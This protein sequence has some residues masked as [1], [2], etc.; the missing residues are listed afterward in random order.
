MEKKYEIAELRFSI[1][2]AGEYY[3]ALTDYF[4]EKEVNE[5]RKEDLVFFVHE[6]EN[7]SLSFTPELYSLS[8]TIAFNHDTFF[9]KRPNFTYSV[10]NLFKKDE[11]TEVH[12]FPRNREKNS[13]VKQ[14]LSS[15]RAMLFGAYVG[16]RD[17]NKDFVNAIANYGCLWYIF[18]VVL[19]KKDCVFVHSGMMA[20][21][22][23]GITL[24]GTG[25]C[26]KTSTMLEM[27]T[28]S[29]YQYISEDFGIVSKAGYL[30]DMQKKAAIY[31]SDVKWGNKYLSNAVKGLGFWKQLEWRLKVMRGINVR[32]NF[33]P[34]EIF[35]ND[36]AHKA[37][38]NTIYALQRT[39]KDSQIECKEIGFE[40]LAER[41]KS[42]SFREIK[43]LYEILCNIRAVG[44]FAYFKDYPSVYELEQQYLDILKTAVRNVKCY[45]ISI[46]INVIPQ[47]TAQELL[48]R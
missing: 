25:G 17:P 18:A 1:Q 42:A 46:P 22:G 4:S 31:Q 11:V 28:H 13:L 32:H 35:G 48:K 8:G 36:I 3:D 30:Y 37:K 2:G 16:K 34:T 41:A 19:M 43:E 33:K 39:R 24:T 15:L 47:D 44:G 45:E 14:W 21:D 27:I 29:D 23:Q 9:V 10:K 5:C 38:L 26:G 40:E 6:M 7:D 20:K 12:L